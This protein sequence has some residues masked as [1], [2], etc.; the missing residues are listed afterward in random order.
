MHEAGLARA[1]VT[2]IIEASEGAPVR[3]VVLAA[4]TGVDIASAT[5]AWQAAAAGTSLETTD[6]CWQRA[7][8]RL[9]CFACGH[10][11]DGA[12]LDPC[13]ACGGNGLVVAPADELA[14]ISWTH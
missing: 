8:D 3:T 5:A 4:A 7:A 9:R 2:A 12:R 13:T 14:V 1:A 10:E 11:Y 6:L